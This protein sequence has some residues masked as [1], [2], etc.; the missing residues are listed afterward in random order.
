MKKKLMVGVLSAVLLAAGA[1]TVLGADAVDSAKL[2]E[3]KSLTQQ[4]FGIQQQIVDKEVEAGLLTQEQ[5]DKL[6]ESISQRKQHSEEALDK[7]QVPGLGLEKHHDTM[8]FKAGEP[9]TEEQIAEWLEK[10]QARLQAQEE[11]MKSSGKLTDEQIAEWLT[12]AQARLDEQ[13]EAMRN[14][15][16]APGD[17]GFGKGMHDGKLFDLPSKDTQSIDS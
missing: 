5:A 15:T 7:G 17:R 11:K 12:K 14:G 1:T 13:K 3:I 6:K 9:L 16:F 10:A 2:A 4:M 8:M